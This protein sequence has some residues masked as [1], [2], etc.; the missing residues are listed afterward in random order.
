MSICQDGLTG[1]A[2]GDWANYTAS[3]LRAE[4]ASAAAAGSPE[5]DPSTQIGA[6]APLG[7][8]DP[9]GFCKK[10]D[11]AGFRNL[12]AAEI[13]HGRAAMM[14]ALGAV[15]QH[16]VKFPGFESVPSGLAAAVTPP[17]SYGFIALFAVSGALELGLW[18]ESDDKEPGNFGDP[19]GFNQYTQEMREREINNGRFAM[20]AALGIISAELYTGKDAIEQNASGSGR[21]TGELC[22]TGSR[23]RGFHRVM[24]SAGADERAIRGPRHRRMFRLA[25]LI[26]LYAG[27][28]ATQ[29][30]VSLALEKRV[31][32]H[33]QAEEGTDATTQH[34]MAYFGTIQVGRPPQNFTVV[35]DTGSGNLIVPG[36]DCTSDACA[37]HRRFDRQ[38]SKQIQSVN[39]DGSKVGYGLEQDEITITFGTGKI[40]GQCFQD[41]ICIGSACSKGNFI[42]ST[43]ES[44]TPFASFSFDGVL[45]LALDSMAQSN[46]FSVMNL[47][48]QSGVLRKPIFSVFLS[49]SEQEKSEITFGDMKQE[50]MASELYWVPV[51]GNAGYWEVEIE[52][53]YFDKKPQN[54]CK[55]CRVAVDTGTSE[56][57]G[58]S[59]VVGKLEELL[60]L[61]D[62]SNVDSLPKLGF[63][64]RGPDGNPK[65]LSLS[66]R[67]YTSEIG[68]GTCNLSL[69]N[70]DVPPPK[71]P[72]FVFGIPFLQKYYTVYDHEKSRVGFAVAK[73]KD[74]VPETLLEVEATAAPG[75]EARL[76][77]S[78]L[79]RK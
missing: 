68:M 14:A 71:G 30:S 74:Q 37:S 2:W 40:T 31:M 15:V 1:S 55:G 38:K 17:G 58:P 34:K 41:D 72:L 69:M 5:F 76:S 7:F 10:G 46:E 79:A 59:S 28:T 42:S 54:L 78:F 48:Q 9:A 11:E 64:V 4:P 35:F 65:I 39:C 25:N 29:S 49:D 77:S 26:L 24:G 23:A 3:P 33:R 12:R 61:G 63:A 51:S 13:K 47:L 27:A 36:R 70:L 53:I 75:P 44:Y 18:T 6:M 52:D 22:G 20:F 60:S 16:Y 57:A 66:P 45:G 21:D 43:E 56:L 8:F 50:H 67:E 73:H 32:Q 62:C 19:V